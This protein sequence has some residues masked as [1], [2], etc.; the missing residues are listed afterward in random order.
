MVLRRLKNILH[1]LNALCACLYYGF[2]AQHITVIGVT[3]TDG[4]T[5]TTHMIYEI[6][7]AAGKRVSMVSTIYAMIGGKSSDTG[8]H[9]TTPSP[10]KIQNLIYEAVAHG[11]EYLVLEVTSH[12]LDQNRVWGIWF[13]TG[14]LTNVT[15]EHIDYHGTFEAYKKAKLKLLSR[16]SFSVIPSEFL[17]DRAFPH[18]NAQTFGLRTGDL[19]L[20]N[21]PITIGM[22]GEYNKLNALAA[23]LVARKIGISDSMIKKTL[24]S[25]TSITGRMEEVYKGAFTVIIDFAHTPNGL[26][27]ALTAVRKMAKKRLILVFGCA[28]RRDIQK[29]PI[30]GNYASEYADVIILTEEDYRDE[31]IHKIMKEIEGGMTKTSPLYKIPDRQKAVDKAVEIARKG[32]IVLMTGKGHERSLCRGTKEYPWSEHTAV[33]KALKKRGLSPQKL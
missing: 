30:M 22:N 11:D 13:A 8:F 4:K 3:G 25:F 14:V 1:L 21:F 18:K 20:K 24:A 26:L 19:T 12:G 15:H 32:D 23:S 29:R 10:W 28:A 33:T 31:D 9:V 27:Q 2:P 6:L 17:K 7:K 16:S 5:T